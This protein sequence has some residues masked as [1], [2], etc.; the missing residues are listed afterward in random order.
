MSNIGIVSA[1]YVDHIGMT[2]PDL[3]QAIA[4]FEKGLG[5]QLLWREGPFHET[6]T[7]VP[8]RDVTLV[9][10]RLGPNINVELMSFEADAQ[11]KQMP[12]NIDYGAAHIAFFVDNLEAAAESLEKNGATLL[13]GPIEASGESKRGERIWYF[14]TPWGAFLE[15]LWR[16]DHLPYERNTT[17]RLF[18]SKDGWTVE[19]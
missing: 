1:S 8:I 11:R 7:G 19:N 17:N 16:P 6:P 14:K 3:D 9:M 12:S 18:K 10:M 13:R 5:A 2:V 15:I 4:F